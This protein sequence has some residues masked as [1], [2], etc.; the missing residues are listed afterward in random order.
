MAEQ[1]AGATDGRGRYA[2]EVITDDD[3]AIAAAL[4]DVSVPTLL[5]SMVHM[6]GDVSILDGPL[7]PAGI[8]LNE[9]QG[10]MAPEDQAAV[11]AW[12]L[13]V[14]AEYRDGG[15]VLPPPPSPHD[16]HRMMSF[17]VAEDVPEEYVPLRARRARARRVRRAGPRLAGA[18]PRGRPPRRPRGR[19]RRRHVGHPRRHPTRSGGH[20]LHDHREEPRHRGHLDREP[21]PG[22]S[23]RR[24]QPLLLLLVRTQRRLDRVL[25]P[26]ARAAALLRGLRPGVR[27]GRAPPRLD[28]GR[29]AP[30]GTT[31][32]A[33]GGSRCDRAEGR[34]T[35][36]AP[37]RSSA[38]WVSSTARRCPTSTGSTP[39]PGSPCTP[40][41]GIE[42]T[43]TGGQAGR[44]DR[45][46]GERLPDRSDDRGGGRAPRGVPAHA[47]RGCSRTRT[48]TSR[49]V[50]ACAGRCATCRTT[51]AGTGSCCSGRRATAACRPWSSTPTTPTRTER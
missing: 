14:I 47:P 11:R 12:A 9:V 37:R 3:E 27:C 49:S 16:V 10:F 35:S 20:P 6:T 18:H 41:S 51:G 29:T 23:R 45:H 50:P 24:R 26:P 21:L 39:S 15:C 19:H 8:Y 38:R 4:E 17:L 5:L 30:S 13:R 36:C 7:R 48:T 42:G 31:R 44:G 25:R 33:P 40:R 43:S 32:R 28:R 1:R 2:G 46:G 22:V 34:P